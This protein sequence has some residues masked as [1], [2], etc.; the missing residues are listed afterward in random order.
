VCNCC[1]KDSSKRGTLIELVVVFFAALI[2]AVLTFFSGFGLGTI[3]LPIFAIFMPISIAIVATAIVHFTNNLFK[4]GLTYKKINSR[5][6][7]YFGAPALVATVVGALVLNS[8]TTEQTVYRW[9]LLSLSGEITILKFLIGILIIIF[10]ILELLTNFKEISFSTK[11]ISL[12]GVLSGFF[13]GL[14]GN[15]GALRS[16]FLIKAGLSKEAFVATGVAIAVIVDFARIFIYGITFFSFVALREEE[17]GG[18]VLMAITGGLVG[19][20]LGKKLLPKVT[21]KY[22]QILVSSLLFLT[23][24]ALVLGFL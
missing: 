14:S 17:V 23:G 16:A 20:L 15:Q 11:W 21:F 24:S 18:L 19:A 9:S 3:L 8:L 4:F 1:F 22:V 5:V 13:G 12:G 10:A 6:L 7:L 2:A